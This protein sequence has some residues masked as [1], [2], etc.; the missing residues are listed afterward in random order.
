MARAAAAHLYVIGSRRGPH[1][2]G[3]SAN[4]RKRLSQLQT[5][6][7]SLLILKRTTATPIA[8]PEAVERYAHWLLRESAVRG[9]W[10]RVTEEAAWVALTA[11]VEA[12]AKGLRVPEPPKPEPKKR[13]RP[14][15]EHEPV[16]I[17]FVPGTKERVRAV[18]E[19]GEDHASFVRTAVDEKIARRLRQARKPKPD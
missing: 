4:P 10:F 19:E 9:E 13:G 3:V 8:E 1:K 12:I 6:T 5:G 7:A 18:L 11:A 15:N 17:R 2:V 16:L 14:L